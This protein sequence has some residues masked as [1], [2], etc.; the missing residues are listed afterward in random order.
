MGRMMEA[1]GLA[2]TPYG[3]VI[4]GINVVIV[5]DLQLVQYQTELDTIGPLMNLL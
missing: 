5:S 2:K 3:I 1:A 4:A